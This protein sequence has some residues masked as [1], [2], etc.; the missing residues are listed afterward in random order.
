M[1][2][3]QAPPLAT[4]ETTCQPILSL[5]VAREGP[6]TVVV[7][8]GPLDMDTAGL[9]VDLVD[10]VMS[11]QPPPVLVL[12][13]SGVA[14]FC[15]AGVTALLAV[16]RRVTSGGCALVVREPSRIT[17]AV[18]EMVGLRHEFTTDGPAFPSTSVGS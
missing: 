15:A 2:V 7:V 18:L 12:D 16:R 6:A 13:L 17:V 14:F 8:R 1:S 10:D 11:G 3:H 9:L 4:R 5:A